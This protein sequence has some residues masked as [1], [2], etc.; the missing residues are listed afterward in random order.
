MSQYELLSKSKHKKLYFKRPSKY[1]FAKGESFLPIGFSELP[2]ISSSLPVVFIKKSDGS[3]VLACLLSLQAGNNEFIDI[4]GKWQ[5]DYTPAFLVTYPFRNIRLEN[6]KNKKEDKHALGFINDSE[7]LSSE[8]KEGFI[9]IFNDDGTI[10]DPAEKIR[11]TLIALEKERLVLNKIILKLERLDVL[12]SITIENKSGD[13][14]LIPNIFSIHSEKLKKLP[15]KQL[16]ELLL[17]STLD[18]IYY[19]KF[20][21]ANFQNLLKKSNSADISTRDQVL[22]AN[23]VKKAAEINTLVKNLLVDD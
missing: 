17:E 20:S 23:K 2:Y 10:S 3:F 15:P 14:T 8:K 5:F 21:L 12:T 11:T 13:K 1:L 4:E 22:M 7:H 18:L 6:P 16:K 9:S 19:Q